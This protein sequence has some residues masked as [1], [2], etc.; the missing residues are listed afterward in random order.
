MATR[1][2]E[3]PWA[4]HA[5]GA[6]ECWPISLRTAVVA[7]LASRTPMQVWAG[8]QAIA[9]YN[10]AA[11][12]L[13]GAAHPAAL[14]TDVSTA[15]PERWRALSSH[16]A[17]ALEEGISVDHEGVVLTPVPDETGTFAHVLVSHP[18][19]DLISV[20]GHELR[21]PLG[22]LSASVQALMLS[23]PSREV[24]LVA[25]ALADVNWLV[26][27]LLDLSRGTKRAVYMRYER[28]E[29]AT[30]VD[31]ALEIAQAQARGRGIELVADVTRTGLHVE[32]DRERLA[33]AIANTICHTL[34]HSALGTR[35]TVLAARESERV[36]IAIRHQVGAG[37]PE[38]LALASAR[39]LVEMHAG[40]LALRDG[41]H[42]L[43][44]PLAPAVDV[45]TPALGNRR[46]VMIVEDNDDAARALKIALEDRGYTVAIAH[47]GPIALQ[48][49]RG[50]APDVVIVDIG[51]PVMDGWE[52]ARRMRA[53]GAE[54]H[55]VAVTGRDQAAD[56]RQSEDLGFAD[57]LV[58]PIDVR[59]LEQLVDSL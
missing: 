38:S 1:I 57:H 47:D 17:N 28:T 6:I 44:L 24:D 15:Q 7:C 2:R 37:V 32:A 21:N 22:V 50:F 19:H 29:I 33:R 12:P 56:H 49:A 18:I 25:R 45:Q 27:D 48:L 26:D 5:L 46:R 43:E 34:Q 35:V 14:G 54:L 52:L 23:S 13:L 3:Y 4:D 53:H 11:L 20:L 58:K 9:I 41:E 31:R 10:D 16:I 40:A 42:V 39:S 59:Q 55:F 30:I 8:P 51:L 36:R